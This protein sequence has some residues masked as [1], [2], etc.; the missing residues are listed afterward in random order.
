MGMTGLDM[1]V[2]QGTQRHSRASSA[3]KVSGQCQKC[4][5][6]ALGQLATG[7]IFFKCHQYVISSGEEVATNPCLFGT[8]PKISP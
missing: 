3:R 5:P 2:L 6:P 7:R 1:C 8:C 4:L